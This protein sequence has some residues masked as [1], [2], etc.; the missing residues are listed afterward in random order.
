[1]SKINPN[2]PKQ[3]FIVPAFNAEGKIVFYILA[4]YYGNAM[5]RLESGIKT[6]AHAVRRLAYWQ[7]DAA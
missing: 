2:K 6:Y 5:K 1:M 7:R 3:Y 4:T